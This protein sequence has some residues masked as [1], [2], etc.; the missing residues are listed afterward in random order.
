MSKLPSGKIEGIFRRYS[1]DCADLLISLRNALDVPQIA[2]GS[3]D[4]AFIA[5]ISGQ[6]PKAVCPAV[7]NDIMHEA[8]RAFGKSVGNMPGDTFVIRCIDVNF[9]S[10]CVVEVLSPV[11]HAVRNAGDVKRTSTAVIG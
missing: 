7:V 5:V 9:I 8:N 11:K 3:Q 10:R 6:N 2:R 4:A 1:S